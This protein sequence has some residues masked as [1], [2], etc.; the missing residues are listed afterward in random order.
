M[1]FNNL[2]YTPASELEEDAQLPLPFADHLPPP[3]SP[4][5]PPRQIV[6]FVGRKR[7]SNWSCIKIPPR[8]AC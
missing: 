8:F 7:A 6:E 2:R 1:F 4:P 5:V 3:P